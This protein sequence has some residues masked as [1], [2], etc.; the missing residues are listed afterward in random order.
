MEE[1]ADFMQEACKYIDNT[2]RSTKFDRT[3]QKVIIISFSFVNTD[4][5]DIF[6]RSF[7]S[8]KWILINTNDALA[9]I[10]LAAREKHF[11]K[12]APKNVGDEWKFA[13]VSFDHLD[14]DGSQTADK[15]TN[16]IVNLIVS[17]TKCQQ[18]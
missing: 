2:I 9:E 11:Y 1:R 4:L 6:I 14:I 16:K 15:N 12:G 5:R 10:R 17:E 3:K 8:A 7:P 18:I 13:K